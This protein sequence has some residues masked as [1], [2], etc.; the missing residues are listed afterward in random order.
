MERS[1]VGCRPQDHL[2]TT[3]AR[4]RDFIRLGIGHT[5]PPTPWYPTPWA[6]MDVSRPC[7]GLVPPISNFDL[8]RMKRTPFSIAS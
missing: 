1:T 8:S 6:R 3:W 5:T 7:C 4:P 2:G